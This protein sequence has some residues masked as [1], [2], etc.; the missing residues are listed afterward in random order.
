MRHSTLLATRGQSFHKSMETGAWRTLKMKTLLDLEISCTLNPAIAY[1]PFFLE[2]AIIVTKS[3]L[4]S[5]THTTG[6]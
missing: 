6:A 5:V 1:P 2:S 3:L 4:H